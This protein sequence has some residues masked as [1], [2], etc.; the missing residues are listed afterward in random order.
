[1]LKESDIIYL[2]NHLVIVRKPAGMLVQGDKTGDET[3]FDQAKLYIK[4]KFKKPGN[5]YL[6]LVHR[7]DRPTSGIICFAKTSKAAAR[8]SRQFQNKTIKKNYLAIVKGKPP[9]QG[10]MID[11]LQ[12][13]KQNSF[14]SHKGK[15]AELYFQRLAY[16]KGQ[17]LV[18]INLKTG[19]H[20]QIRVQFSHRGFSVL[21][22]F[23]YG[24]KTKFPNRTLALHAY[25]LTL[26]HPTRKEP[27]TFYDLPEW[28]HS[29]QPLAQKFINAQQHH[30]DRR[31]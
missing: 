3:L 9:P 18:S 25:S 4:I 22:D 12:R 16:E 5:V 14:V 21:G 31:R 7:L 29:F 30:T 23:R 24:S 13:N 20:H 1:M 27:M 28:H 26:N 10:R 11:K 15:K 8:L 17:S 6:G 19:R 2:D